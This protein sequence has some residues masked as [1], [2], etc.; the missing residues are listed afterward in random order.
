MKIGSVTNPIQIYRWIIWFVVEDSYAKTVIYGH[1]VINYT[2]VRQEGRL[3]HVQF[4][5]T[6][7]T[8]YIF[9]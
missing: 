8:G 4:E 6:K 1:P 3:E 9:E 2:Y 7:I 5:N